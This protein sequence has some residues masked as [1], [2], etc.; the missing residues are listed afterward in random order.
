MKPG[1]FARHTYR[2]N[3]G[4]VDCKCL[5]GRAEREYMPDRDFNNNTQHKIDGPYVR[6]KEHRSRYKTWGSKCYEHKSNRKW[7]VKRRRHENHSMR[8]KLRQ[9]ITFGNLATV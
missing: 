3:V 2:A 9:S 4:A 8:N 1:L 5:I 7:L 6:E